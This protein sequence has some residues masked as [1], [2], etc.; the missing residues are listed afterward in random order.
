MQATKSGLIL[1][2]SVGLG[3]V[4]LAV[5]LP[6]PSNFV[7]LGIGGF[8][9]SSMLGPRQMPPLDQLVR[10]HQPYWRLFAL[11]YYLF[12]AALMLYGAF[13]REELLHFLMD[14]GV[15][16]FLLLSALLGP[17]APFVYRHERERYRK[18]P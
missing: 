13:A 11:P 3:T 7:A 1:G 15:G 9:A 6:Y 14:P 18:A 17:F 2:W 4:L 5:L 16:L 8:I 10:E 12:L